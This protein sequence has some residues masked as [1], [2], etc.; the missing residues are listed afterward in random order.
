MT[1]TVRMIVM[2]A[3]ALEIVLRCGKCHKPTSS[4]VREWTDTAMEQC[5]HCGDRW[6]EREHVAEIRDALAALKAL[7][8]WYDVADEPT[9]PF[10][11]LFGASQRIG[12]A[13]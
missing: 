13:A 10:T 7:V 6:T 2:D 9:V 1:E 11:V 5:P 8:Q 12:K 4:K 3:G